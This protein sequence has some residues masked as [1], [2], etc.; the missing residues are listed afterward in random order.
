MV[1]YKSMNLI[2]CPII[3]DSPTDHHCRAFA[4]YDLQ[5]KFPLYFQY[6]TDFFFV[7]KTLDKNGIIHWK[8]VERYFTMGLFVFQFYP[9]CNFGTSI[10]D[11]TLSGLK[12]LRFYQE[13]PIWI[14]YMIC[15]SFSS[16]LWKGDGTFFPTFAVSLIVLKNIQHCILYFA[17]SS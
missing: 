6:K 3:D 7:N 17:N 15:S 9:V 11:L 1:D 4:I 16:H 8:A 13:V 5:S 2:G 12:G 14:C 10:L